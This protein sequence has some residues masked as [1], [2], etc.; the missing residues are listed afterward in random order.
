MRVINALSVVLLLFTL[1]VLAL[2]CVSGYQRSRGDGMR[3]DGVFGYT[4]VIVESGSMEETIRTHGIVI[5]KSVKDITLLKERDIII[6]DAGEGI[7]VCRRIIAIKP[8]GIYTRGDAAAIEDGTPLTEKEIF[9][10]VPEKRLCIWNWAASIVERIRPEKGIIRWLEALKYIGYVFLALLA[11]SLPFYLL[12][13]SLNLRMR[14]KEAAVMAAAQAE[15]PRAAKKAKTK[16]YITFSKQGNLFSGLIRLLSLL[17]LVVGIFAAAGVGSW[18][19]VKHQSVKGEATLGYYIIHMD[20]NN[21]GSTIYPNSDFLVKAIK[22]TERA[23]H[24]AVGNKS[25]VFVTYRQDGKILTRQLANTLSGNFTVRE[26]IANSAPSVTLIPYADVLGIVQAP[27]NWTAQIY[28]DLDSPAGIFKWIALPVMLLVLLFVLL[29][30]LMRVHIV[31]GAAPL[32]AADSSAIPQ[33]YE[34]VFS[35]GLAQLPPMAP[36]VILP[37][38]EEHSSLPVLPLATPRTTPAAQMESAPA[39]PE[40]DFSD[41]DAILGLTA[42]DFS[43]PKSVAPQYAAKERAEKPALQ[44]PMMD[45]SE[46]DFDSFLAE[47]LKD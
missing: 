24:E 4:P 7:S 3:S 40:I 45:F 6:F 33:E 5:M 17:V 9:G 27:M 18:T 36:P 20:G 25:P 29:R 47:K 34:D 30:L 8:D 1:T 42:Q 44:V 39:L 13:R 43:A 11:S 32:V 41:I 12:E 19:F 28:R 16:R 15:V 35:N 46:I 21:P 14:E 37:V 2:A 31:S 22:N 26:S 10:L 38:W 23:V